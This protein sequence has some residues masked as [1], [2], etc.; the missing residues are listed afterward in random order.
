IVT[1]IGFLGAGTIFRSGAS[2]RGLTTAA[3]IWLVAGVGMGI[4]N[5][6]LLRDVSVI[7]ALLVCSVNT[8]VRLVENRW[9]RP[10]HGLRLTTARKADTLADILE[11]LDRRGVQVHELQ[12]LATDASA[13]E[14]VVRMA[15]HIP[16][17][18]SRSELTSWISTQRGVR[19][20]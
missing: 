19:E 9:V 14:A 2:V 4:A 5:G 15:L 18:A 1:G 16:M 13:D 17:S 7:T 6:G 20:V 10:H 3:G 11:G 8:L 12:W